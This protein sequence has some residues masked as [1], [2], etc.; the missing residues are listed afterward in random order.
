MIKLRVNPND[1]KVPRG[2]CVHRLSVSTAARDVFAF[3]EDISPHVAQSLAERIRKLTGFF[4]PVLDAHIKRVST[5]QE[6][7]LDT[8]IRQDNSGT[9]TKDDDTRE[10]KEPWQ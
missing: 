8:A 2:D 3:V 7:W 10:T 9:A 4:A 5:Q 6:K 1:L